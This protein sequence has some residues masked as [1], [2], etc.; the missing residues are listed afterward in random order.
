MSHSTS[1]GERRVVL[2]R[3]RAD[4]GVS[5]EQCLVRYEQDSDLASLEYSYPDGTVDADDEF[6]SN[7]NWPDTPQFYDQPGPM[8]LVRYERGTSHN[9]SPAIEEKLVPAS[10]YG[11][12]HHHFNAI[13]AWWSWSCI[14]RHYVWTR[15]YSKTE[16]RKVL[17]RFESDLGIDLLEM[18]KDLRESDWDFY[19]GNAGPWIVT[20]TYNQ[21]DT[22]SYALI[23]KDGRLRVVGMDLRADSDEISALS[24]W[25][26]IYQESP[27]SNNTVGFQLP[28]TKGDP[29]LHPCKWLVPSDYLRNNR[30]YYSED[31]VRQMSTP[32]Q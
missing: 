21:N 28:C 22:L 14:P 11:S 15:A 12:G 25:D 10:D 16:E 3:G 26:V 9:Q 19:G 23:R 1:R 5:R 4:E 32:T 31:E 30:L 24:Q 6:E 17:K 27:N 8:A 18:T 2:Y 7:E 13:T 29:E 20:I